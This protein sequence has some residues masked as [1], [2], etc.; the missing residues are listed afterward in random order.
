MGTEPEEI[1]AL[2]GPH[3]RKH[4]TKVL[5]MVL[6]A[7]A[8]VGA[9]ATIVISSS[10]GARVKISQHTAPPHHTQ[11]ASTAPPPR[12]SPAQVLAQ[13]FIHASFHPPYP[14]ISAY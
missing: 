13:Q 9:L 4:S 12:L 3:R 11:P 7:I 6:L 5:V 2:P 14:P 10:V 1:Q 8:L